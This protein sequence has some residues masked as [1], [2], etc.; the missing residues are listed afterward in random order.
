MANE[1]LLK[2]NTAISLTSVSTPAFTLTSLATV[3]GR[4]SAQVDFGSTFERVWRWRLKTKFAVAPVE[5]ALLEIYLATSDNTIRDGGLGSADAALSPVAARFQCQL[6]G[7]MYCQATT[8]AQYSSGNF[9]MSSR[10]ASVIVY[11]ATTQALSATAGDHEFILVP[12]ADEV[13]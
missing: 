3:S 10:Y 6:I 8:D 7:A 12:Y 11:N 5:G 2:P 9:L 4:I 1:I 13:Q